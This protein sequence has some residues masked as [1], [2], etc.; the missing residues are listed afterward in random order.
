MSDR[1]GA[2]MVSRLSLSACDRHRFEFEDLLRIKRRKGWRRAPSF[3]QPFRAGLSCVGPNGPQEMQIAFF[4]KP[5]KNA[6]PRDPALSRDC[7]LRSLAPPTLRPLDHFN[8]FNVTK[9]D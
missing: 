1:S 2:S 9:I 4:A 7:R 5:A 6:E 8:S 3:S